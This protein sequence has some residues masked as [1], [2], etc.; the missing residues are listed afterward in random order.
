MARVQALLEPANVTKAPAFPELDVALSNQV[1]SGVAKLRFVPFA[2]EQVRPE[3][4]ARPYV[5]ANDLLEFVWLC[6]RPEQQ[7]PRCD[8]H[9]N[10]ELW[11]PQFISMVR[12]FKA[13]NRHAPGTMED[14]YR[15]YGA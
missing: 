11:G 9:Y 4:H 1:G 3:A 2:A 12:Y 6:F 14:L 10:Y 8:D 5:F 7:R 15:E 13:P